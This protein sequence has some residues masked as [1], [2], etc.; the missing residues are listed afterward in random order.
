M[1]DFPVK[2]DN[3]MREKFKSTVFI[4][5]FVSYM[6]AVSLLVALA[7]TALFSSAVGHYQAEKERSVE[8]QLR[9]AADAFSSVMEECVNVT[10]QIAFNNELS[11]S[12]LENHPVHVIEGRNRLSEYL[13]GNAFAENILLYFPGSDI[14]YTNNGTMDASLASEHGK[15]NLITAKRVFNG[16][17]KTLLTYQPQQRNFILYTY[18]Y[19]YKNQSRGV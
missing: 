7:C 4:R 9:Q 19:S 8:F 15:L 12:W 13:Q 5:Y 16:Q 10:Y 18:F 11:Q 14:V 3:T 2:E 1:A 17:E 6:A